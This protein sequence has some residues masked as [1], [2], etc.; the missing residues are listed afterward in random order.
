MD[1]L[2]EIRKKL[3]YFAGGRNTPFIDLSTMVMDGERVLSVTAIEVPGEQNTCL[4]LLRDLYPTAGETN[5][6]NVTDE[7]RFKKRNI[8]YRRLDISDALLI[9]FP[10]VDG[11]VAIDESVTHSHPMDAAALITLLNNKFGYD[12]TEDDIVLASIR[13]NKYTITAK[14]NSLGFIK[15]VSVSVGDEGDGPEPEPTPSHDALINAG[16]PVGDLVNV[17]NVSVNMTNAVAAYNSG[18]FMMKTTTAPISSWLIWHGATDA[19]VKFTAPNT[20]AS[21]APTNV[22]ETI[23]INGTQVEFKTIPFTPDRTIPTPTVV[24]DYD[25]SVV[26]QFPTSHIPTLERLL[27]FWVGNANVKLADIIA[28]LVDGISAVV[29]GAGVATFSTTT[30]GGEIVDLIIRG[31]VATIPASAYS[32]LRLITLGGVPITTDTFGN[33]LYGMRITADV[34]PV[35]V[36]SLVTPVTATNQALYTALMRKAALEVNELPWG[37]YNNVNPSVTNIDIRQF[38]LNAT[39]EV[40]VHPDWFPTFYLIDPSS[41]A[42]VQQSPTT[43]IVGTVT[44]R[45]TETGAETSTNLTVGALNALGEFVTDEGLYFTIKADLPYRKTVSLKMNYDPSGKVYSEATTSVI[46]QLNY[47]RPSLISPAHLTEAI[48]DLFTF[49]PADNVGIY[50]DQDSISREIRADSGAY[51]IAVEGFMPSNDMINLVQFHRISADA[52]RAIGE[53]ALSNPTAVVLRKVPSDGSAETVYSAAMLNE[54]LMKDAD[55][56]GYLADVFPFTTATVTTSFT[57]ICDYDG[58]GFRWKETETPVT[59]NLKW[60]DLPLVPFDSE[61]DEELDQSTYIEAVEYY[62]PLTGKLFLEPQMLDLNIAVAAPNGNQNGTL[63]RKVADV[64]GRS[65]ILNIIVPDAVALWLTSEQA[66]STILPDTVIVKYTAPVGG[67]VTEI[68]FKDLPGFIMLGNNRYKFPVLLDTGATTVETYTGLHIFDCNWL[69][70]TRIPGSSA[71]N[72]VNGRITLLLEE[73]DDVPEPLP[74]FLEYGF[75]TEAI[76]EEIVDTLTVNRVLA[77]DDVSNSVASND[78]PPEGLDGSTNF[79]TKLNMVIA[80][81]GDSAV[82]LTFLRTDKQ[83]GAFIRSLANE[84]DVV[85]QF[86]QGDAL[87]DLTVKHI[88]DHSVDDDMHTWIP[89]IR[90]V[91]IS[92]SKVFRDAEGNIVADFDLEGNMYSRMNYAFTEMLENDYAVDSTFKVVQP[93]DGQD[94]MDKV[95]LQW[96]LENNLWLDYNQQNVT[97]NANGLFGEIKITDRNNLDKYGFLVAEVSE[98]YSIRLQEVAR[99]NPEAVLFTLTSNF[100][101]TPYRIT[102]KQF[103]ENGA[104]YNNAYHYALPF[105]ISDQTAEITLNSAADFDGGAGPALGKTIKTVLTVVNEIVP[106]VEVTAKQII[107]VD[108]EEWDAWKEAWPSAGFADKVEDL[109][110]ELG[111][112]GLIAT[113]NVDYKN[114]KTEALMVIQVDKALLDATT[115]LSDDIVGVILFGRPH[116]LKTLREGPK[117]DGNPLVSWNVIP[118]TPVVSD[119]RD[120]KINVVGVKAYENDFVMHYN[121]VKSPVAL[122]TIELKDSIDELVTNLTAESNPVVNNLLPS[123]GYTLNVTEAEGEV[124]YEFS[125]IFSDKYDKDVLIPIGMH[126]DQLAYSAAGQYVLAVD[127]GD[128]KHLTRADMDQATLEGWH[129]GDNLQLMAFPLPLNAITVNQYHGIYTANVIEPVGLFEQTTK[130]VSV[131]LKPQEELLADIALIVPNADEFAGI[132]AAQSTLNVDTYANN[133]WRERNGFRRTI[134]PTSTKAGLLAVRLEGEAVKYLVDPSL[135]DETEILVIETN[136][137]PIA[138][139]KADMAT[140]HTTGSGN[141]KTYYF[142]IPLPILDEVT[143]IT[144][145]ASAGI[146]EVVVGEQEWLAYGYKPTTISCAGGTSELAV[147]TFNEAVSSGEV[148]IEG[149][150]AGTYTNFPELKAILE[151]HGYDV[152]YIEAKPL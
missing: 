130:R 128:M 134:T 145:K 59:M 64:F 55:G 62:D 132:V 127:E 116:S 70:H 141:S 6:F 33:E 140:L 102:H 42:V 152:T 38:G 56:D 27:S 95:V 19:V 37:T 137:V 144:I 25:A 120:L 65:A 5:P 52:V 111:E 125:G 8:M 74:S 149:V 61:V 16:A 91:D 143:Q 151:G 12:F 13:G 139:T 43:A 109:G 7:D 92:T 115:E 103:L 14:E 79:H 36:P 32:E 110:I 98:E 40:D 106:D 146:K 23:K 101:E 131:V 17:N 53:I 58:V 39:L 93:A 22:N 66:K 45:D 121:V 113:R 150:S 54:A 100:K 21:V 69:G 72:L 147:G 142:G 104:F 123:D 2:P 136:G 68:K 129:L 10:L 31:N 49:E 84:S 112:T 105:I 87:V 3:K 30:H 15:S 108:Q 119:T 11:V 50:V 97:L 60:V 51:T 29:D 35:S 63:K 133:E 124:T 75:P 88:R 24:G 46:A 41:W 122:D 90:E 18:L 67:G 77:F 73:I 1:N 9:T 76:Y 135:D 114:F 34:A 44:T 94:W 99:E 118:Q 89:V 107:P 117:R 57:W 80:D 20:G 4:S 148:F 28:G 86:Q 71:P 81:Y 138:V 83:H 78:T 47:A 85:I 26:V 126:K 48:F 82:W 96:P